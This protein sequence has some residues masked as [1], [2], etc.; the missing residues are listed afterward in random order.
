MPRDPTSADEFV[1][2][3]IISQ[4]SMNPISLR[5]L[6]SND[7]IQV[8]LQGAFRE[9]GYFL[10]IKRGY[11]LRN[12]SL[13]AK[14][15]Y[16]FRP[17]S[18]EELALAFLATT[19]PDVAK[20]RRAKLFDD[21]LYNEVF[22][23]DMTVHDYLFAHYLLRGVLHS[24]RGR[25]GQYHSTSIQDF[26]PHARLHALFVLASA[27]QDGSREDAAATCE[28]VVAAAENDCDAFVD[29]LRRPADNAFEICYRAFVAENGQKR[30]TAPN[31]FIRE[32]SR[33]RVVRLM[34]A[35]RRKMSKSLR[36]FWRL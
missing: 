8:A 6:K 24:Y 16:R 22:S 10:E 25:R 30:V 23:D 3:T 31:F 29:S 36:P 15:L 2:E 11:G 33:T 27:I 13:A 17:I 26:K 28:R 1:G 12:L 19:K 35:D 34:R 14:R 7:P 21:D 5:D 9:R 32:S 20:Y 18:N 4:N